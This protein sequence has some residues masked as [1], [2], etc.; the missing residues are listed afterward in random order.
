MQNK[1]ISDDIVSVLDCVDDN[2]SE[3]E[4]SESDNE[5]GDN[6]ECDYR[7]G[8]SDSEQSDR[9]VAPAISG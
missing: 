1:V 5:I 8:I 7:S 2:I 3:V 9:Q 6:Q 4:S